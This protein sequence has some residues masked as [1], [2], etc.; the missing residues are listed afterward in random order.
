M[1]P[2]VTRSAMF[3]GTA[4][5]CEYL[6]DRGED[7]CLQNSQ[8]KWSWHTRKNKYWKCCPDGQT[9]SGG[10]YEVIEY[11]DWE[12]QNRDCEPPEPPPPTQQTTSTGAASKTK[13]KKKVAKLHKKKKKK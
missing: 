5:T 9:G 10:C 11:G 13:T 1:P 6:F 4:L 8:G 7:A 3:D 12:D 2:N